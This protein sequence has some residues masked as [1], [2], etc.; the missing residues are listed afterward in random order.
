MFIRYGTGSVLMP[1]M[2]ISTSLLQRDHCW[3]VLHFSSRY[4]CLLRAELTQV[5]VSAGFADVEWLMP[6]VTGYYQPIVS[7]RVPKIGLRKSRLRPGT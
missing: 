6:P 7:G 1:M 5:S 2:C 4:R 3:E